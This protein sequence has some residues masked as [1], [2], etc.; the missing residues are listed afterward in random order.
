MPKVRKWLCSEGFDAFGGVDYLK[1]FF[2]ETGAKIDLLQEKE[3]SSPTIDIE[4]FIRQTPN[5]IQSIMRTAIEDRKNTVK[6]TFIICGQLNSTTNEPIDSWTFF[7]WLQ[8]HGVPSRYVVWRKHCMIERMRADN[9]LKD[10][11]LLSGNGVD[12]FEFI[13][14]SSLIQS[15]KCNMF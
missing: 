4:Y 7:R 6:D 8:D 3:L 11:I 13:D 9:G 10:V 5:A 2:P 12:D 14:I 15:C 1:R